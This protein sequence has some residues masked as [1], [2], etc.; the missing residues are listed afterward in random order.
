MTSPSFRPGLTRPRVV[1][2]ITSH[3]DF[4]F[5]V[6]MRE[7]PDLFELRLDRIVDVVNQLEKKLSRLRAPLIITARHPM[8]GGANQLSAL[9][10]FNLL[11]RF[12]SRARYID[13]ELRSAPVFRSLL[14]LARKES[15]RCIISVHHLK[16][17]PPPGRLRTQARAAKRYGADIFK[18][19]TRTDTPAQLTRLIDFVAAKDV[20]VVVSA[21]GMG[22]L[23]AASRVLLACCGSALVY[24]S[25][26][27]SDIEGQMSLEQLR[28]LG[29]AA[30][31]G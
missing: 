7:P 12:L 18:L 27:R 5:A 10:R 28:V 20:D 26:G 25:L 22:K 14:R 11:A 6:R 4:N 31:K 16:S 21:M 3:A 30:L 29:F 23:G 19:A 1:G 8:E 2:V 24:V 17:T 13:V 9:Q 15:V